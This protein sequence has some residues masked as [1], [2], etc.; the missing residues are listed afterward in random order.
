[1]MNSSC[2]SCAQPPIYLSQLAQLLSP[3]Q[4]AP[5]GD[6]AHKDSA[7]RTAWMGKYLSPEFY[8]YL[9][10]VGEKN[11]ARRQGGLDLSRLPLWMTAGNSCVILSH[12]QIQGI[13]PP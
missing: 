6:G 11:A 1:M 10:T 5:D 9:L 12:E 13:S 2:L 4:R 7:Q 8:A 3:I